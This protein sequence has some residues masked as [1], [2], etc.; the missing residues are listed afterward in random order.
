ME[1]ERCP[2]CGGRA[3][4]EPG[5]VESERGRALLSFSLYCASCGAHSGKSYG[6]I[7]VGLQ[8]DGKVFVDDTMLKEAVDKWNVRDKK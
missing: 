3:K 8:C 6:H 2:Y 4:I 5:R 7:T 1:L